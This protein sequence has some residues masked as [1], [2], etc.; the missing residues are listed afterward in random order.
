MANDKSNSILPYVGWGVFKTTVDNLA[1]TVV[2]TGPLDRRVLHFLSGADHGALISALR[3]F[4]LA[5]ESKVAS[6]EYRELVR[7][8]KDPAAFKAGLKRLLDSRYAPIIGKVNLQHGT[9]TELERAFKDYGVAQGQMLTKTIRFFVKALQECGVEL[10]PHITKPSP[11]ARSASRS[12]GEKRSPRSKGQGN[13][14]KDR[15]ELTQDELPQGFE[16]MPIPGLP[17][18]FIQYPVGLTVEQC[19]LFTAAIAFLKVYVT[20]KLDVTKGVES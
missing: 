6:P 18:A 19:N 10:S 3:F 7:S 11:K 12:S 20:G 15:A 13:D 2:P 4:G 16:R 14:Q 9:I 5:D 8:S 1:E 17:Q